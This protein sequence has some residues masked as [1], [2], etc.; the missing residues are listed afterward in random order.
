MGK[1]FTVDTQG[2]NQAAATFADLSQRY[3][4]IAKQLMQNAETMGAAWDAP[5]NLAFVAQIQG[6]TDD[7]QMMSKKLQTDSE[8]L[9]KMSETYQKRMEENI[10]QVKKLS[11]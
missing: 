4:E 10:T 8:A 7:L 11:N 6:L 9:K 1:I 2:I 3:A 5:D